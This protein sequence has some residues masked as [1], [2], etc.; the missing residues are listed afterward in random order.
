MCDRMAANVFGYGDIVDPSSEDEDWRAIHNAQRI[1][2]GLRYSHRPSAPRRI[3][4]YTNARYKASPAA[5]SHLLIEEDIFVQYLY[6][7][8]RMCIRHITL[9]SLL[10]Q[11][12]PEQFLLS[13]LDKQLIKSIFVSDNDLVKHFILHKFPESCGDPCGKKICNCSNFMINLNFDKICRIGQFLIDEIINLEQYLDIR[14]ANQTRRN[15]YLVVHGRR[16]HH[17]ITDSDKI[18]YKII[19]EKLS[20]TG[21]NTYRRRYC[22]FDDTDE[23]SDEEAGSRRPTADRLRDFLYYRPANFRKGYDFNN[24]FLMYKLLVCALSKLSYLT[25]HSSMGCF[26]PVFENNSLYN[27]FRNLSDFNHCN[28]SSEYFSGL[29]S[30]D[31]FKVLKLDPDICTCLAVSPEIVCRE[32][33]CCQTDPYF[34]Y[35]CADVVS[36]FATNWMIME[37][38]Y[39]KSGYWLKAKDKNFSFDRPSV[40]PEVRTWFVKFLLNRSQLDFSGRFHDN[41]EDPFVMSGHRAANE[42]NEED[43]ADSDCADYDPPVQFRSPTNKLDKFFNKVFTLNSSLILLLYLQTLNQLRPLKGR[44]RD[45][46]ED[47]TIKGLDIMSRYSSKKFSRGKYGTLLPALAEDYMISGQFDSTS[48]HH[49]DINSED[50]HSSRLSSRLSYTSSGSLNSIAGGI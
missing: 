18:D 8:T 31:R 9:L 34:V 45:A 21:S 25:A 15:Q 22:L 3:T 39:R 13:D 24:Y 2:R 35:R 50:L 49:T 37:K 44:V 47:R 48:D 10:S 4:R 16:P 38:S 40:R 5:Q 29:S 28:N 23:S 26:T 42:A 46:E 17:R 20:Q 41:L 30:S 12:R 32:P 1:F 14:P 11:I 36:N 7:K 6:L 33:T 27:G 19:D 43:C